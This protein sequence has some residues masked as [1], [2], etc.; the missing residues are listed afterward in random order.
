MDVSIEYISAACNQVPHTVALN[1]NDTSLIYG[2]CNSIIQVEIKNDRMVA[3]KAF[4]GHTD[5]VNCVRW[6]GSQSFVTGSTDK[7]VC[8]WENFN[9]IQV[10]TK[11]S[12][13]IS[14]DFLSQGPLEK[15][16]D[17]ALYRFSFYEMSKGP[18]I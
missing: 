11:N 2:A 18:S 15:K 17:R 9:V 3:K 1:K 7:K 5:R 10:R 14:L 12:S 4:I 13:H 16:K 6:T 8:L